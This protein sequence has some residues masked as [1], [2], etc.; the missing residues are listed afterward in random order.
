MSDIKNFDNYIKENINDND[1]FE[2][3]IQNDEKLDNTERSKGNLINLC[4]T[5]VLDNLM[6]HR[7]L[8]ID[9][10]KDYFNNMDINDLKEFLGEQEMI[11]CPD[12][13]GTGRMED[14]ITLCRTCFGTGEIEE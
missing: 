13:L 7:H 2:E 3:E 10:L 9:L 14:G 5:D 12:C 4:I 6:D 11:E 8:I 1:P